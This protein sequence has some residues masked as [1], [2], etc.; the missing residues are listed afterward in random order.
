MSHYHRF[1][2]LH[3]RIL[4]MICMLCVAV[5]FNGVLSVMQELQ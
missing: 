3:A 5:D 4:V 2:T 1:L